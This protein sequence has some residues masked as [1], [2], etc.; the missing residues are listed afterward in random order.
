MTETTPRYR[1]IAGK[2][3]DGPAQRVITGLTAAGADDIAHLLAKDYP[4]VEI[5]ALTVLA[6]V[7][8]PASPTQPTAT[9][10]EPQPPSEASGTPQESR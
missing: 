6:L 8:P 2:V 4:F 3:L 9:Q 7:P 1:I 10:P 5:Q